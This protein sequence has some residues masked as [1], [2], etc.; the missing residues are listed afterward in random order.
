MKEDLYSNNLS[1]NKG[2][3]NRQRQKREKVGNSLGVGARHRLHTGSRQVQK[4]NNAVVEQHMT[5]DV[6][7]ITSSS[8][9]SNKCL[10]TA[11]IS[12]DETKKCNFKE[13]SAVP[14]SKK[15]H[16]PKAVLLQDICDNLYLTNYEYVPLIPRYS[17]IIN[18]SSQDFPHSRPIGSDDHFIYPIKFFDNN[19]TKYR[20]FLQIVKRAYDIIVNAGTSKKIYLVC[21]KGVNR[22]AAIAIAYAIIHKK[23]TFY[24][25][26]DY[27]EKEKAKLGYPSW[28]TLT[29]SCFANFL[30]ML[31]SENLHENSTS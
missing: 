9:I 16:R 3:D 28:D 4:R 24:E 7:L 8:N 31:Q 23:W 19:E 21:D 29:N 22:S 5:D 14:R 20:E 27:I 13:P 10:P 30:V 2:N 26:R 11:A 6:V 15:S 18:V 1:H 17:V 12:E 25:A